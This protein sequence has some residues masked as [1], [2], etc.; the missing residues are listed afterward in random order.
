MPADLGIAFAKRVRAKHAFAKRVHAKHAKRV[1]EAAIAIAKR[2][3]ARAV[4]AALVRAA[5]RDDGPA[6]EWPFEG[7]AKHVSTAFARH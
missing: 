3:R 6:R 1:Y 2:V 7:T 4:R 5:Y